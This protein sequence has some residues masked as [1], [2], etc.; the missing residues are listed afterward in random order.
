MP[1]LPLRARATAQHVS[2]YRAIGAARKRTR[3]PR[4]IYPT[5]IEQSYYLALKTIMQRVRRAFDP[6]FA[7]LPEILR[8]SANARA[9]ANESDQVSALV[10]QVEKTI[11]TVVNQKDIAELAERYART[12]AGYQKEQL[13]KQTKSALG[14]D[15]LIQDRTLAKRIEGFAAENAALIKG[16]S[17][18][19]VSAIEK[20]ALRAVQ[21]GTLYSDLQ[22]EIADRF[23]VGDSRARLIARDQIGKL[24]GQVNAARQKELGISK[25]IWRTVNDGRVRDEHAEREG[26]EYSYDDPP[27]GELPGEPIQCRCSAEPVFTDILN[28]LE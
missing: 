21:D 9:D 7:A 15:V 17:Q 1:T 11:S 26:E 4:Q 19:I 25:F 3:M 6:L 24:Y 18:E 5:R 20:A 23:D 22:K 2:V 14:V 13:A 16:L 10:D 28:E 27:D 8:A 12:T